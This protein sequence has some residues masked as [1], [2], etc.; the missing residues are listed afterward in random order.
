M[1]HD[2][3]VV[4]CSLFAR[5]FVRLGHPAQNTLLRTLSIWK[6]KNDCEVKKFTKPD[7]SQQ[8]LPSLGEL[9]AEAV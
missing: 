1:P 8:T 5:P 4:G 9:L 3:L 7:I 6:E 2:E